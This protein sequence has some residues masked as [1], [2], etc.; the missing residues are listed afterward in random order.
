MTAQS[1]F[2]VTAPR[3]D[4]SGSLATCKAATLTLD[5]ALAGRRDAL[6]PAGLLLAAS[7]ARLVLEAHHDAPDA[8]LRAAARELQ[9]RFRIR[10][11]TLQF[12]SADCPGGGGC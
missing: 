9:E 8:L 3:V 6:D 1:K 10:H 7:S 12:E 4:D 5:T 11:A 2:S